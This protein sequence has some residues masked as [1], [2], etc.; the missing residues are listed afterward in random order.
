MLRAA[1]ERG[2]VRRDANIEVALDMIYGALFY[3][4]LMGHAPLDDALVKQVLKE[5]LRGLRP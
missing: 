5:A 3:R 4:L 2:D 1:I